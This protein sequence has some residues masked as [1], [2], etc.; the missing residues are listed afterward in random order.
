MNLSQ[1]EINK[2]NNKSFFKY[3]KNHINKRNDN[4]NSKLKTRTLIQSKS[5]MSLKTN[6][7]KLYLVTL[8]HS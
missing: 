5:E 6:I 4:S 8:L 1:N 7:N 3:D 2:K